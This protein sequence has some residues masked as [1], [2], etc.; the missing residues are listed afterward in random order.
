MFRSDRSFMPCR[1]ERDVPDEC[2]AES[3]FGGCFTHSSGDETTSAC[4]DNLAAYQEAAIS[5]ETAPNL[6]Y[7]DCSEMYGCWKEGSTGNCEPMCDESLCMEK[8]HTCS[9][10]GMP[11]LMIS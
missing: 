1:C 6:S 8:L 10:S 4:V 11:H 2:T 3:D 5:G 9:K 7:C